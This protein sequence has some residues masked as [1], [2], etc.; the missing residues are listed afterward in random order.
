MALF[1]A[2]AHARDLQQRLQIL[3]PTA[4]FNATPTAPQLDA[5]GFP[6]ISFTHAGETQWIYITTEY[7]AETGA[8]VG[9]D[10]NGGQGATPSNHV[11]GLGLPQRVYSPHMCQIYREAIATPPADNNGQNAVLAA[12]ALMGMKVLIWE[13]TGVESTT[14]LAGAQAAATTLVTK[15]PSDYIN[16]LTNS[17]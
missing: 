11:D 9:S 6:I 15:V 3:V 10:P 4:V 17:Q 2:Q 13:G 16:P 14:T 5:L 12:V 1:K 7:A 8:P